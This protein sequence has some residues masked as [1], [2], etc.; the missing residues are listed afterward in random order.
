MNAIECL[1]LHSLVKLLP[2][3]NPAEEDRLGEWTALRGET[4]SVQLAIRWIEPSEPAATR[5]CRL[6]VTCD[7]LKPALFRVLDVPVRMPS[8]AYAAQDPDYLTHVPG[9]LPDV[10]EPASAGGRDESAWLRLPQNQWRVFWV[11]L[12]I[13]S[14]APAGKRPLKVTLS[15]ENGEMIVEQTAELDV[16][17]V[18]LPDQE[19]RVTQWFH[20]DCLADY[21]QMPVFSEEHWRIIESF[22]GMAAAHGVNGLL[23]PLFTPPLDTAI[24]GQRTTVQLV[25]VTRA[26]SGWQ[27][28]FDRLDRWIAMGQRLGFRF[29]E[30]S[31]LF[32]Q[33]GAKAAP[34]IIA[35]VDGAPKRVFGWDTPA[36]G[37]EYRL[38]LE[39][40]LPALVARLGQLGIGPERCYMHISDE[41]SAENLASYQA[42]KDLVK[43]LVEPY[44]IID[45]LSDIAFYHSGAVEHPI[46][47]SNHIEPFLEAGIK[48]LWTYYCCGQSVDVSN[49]FIAMPSARNRIIGAQ[50]FRWNITGF[51]QWGYNFYNSVHSRRPVNPFLENDADYAFPA[52]DAFSVYPG[53]GGFPLASL[54]L[55]VFGHALADLRALRLL[56]E[57]LGRA[58]AVDWLDR[59]SGA[60]IRFSEYPRD[61]RWLLRF[62]HDLNLRL[63]ELA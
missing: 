36:V 24:G 11:D 48:D 57:R 54:R 9:L 41:P 43:P 58:A 32:T 26:A 13:P 46:P 10:L 35:T 30:M 16:L 50:M 31:H 53:C 8:Y 5:T 17:D 20:S 59:Q 42:A 27:F 38:F 7:D 23:T 14:S 52:G 44:P 33:W 61:A 22:A 45:A 47:A 56:E 12:A 60:P 28:G 51:L 3:Q 39:A 6:R 63:A 25:D 2:G 4:T 19:L 40:F 55:K 62:R 15:G 18:V 29:F 1:F 37:E 34:K 49:R 21:Y